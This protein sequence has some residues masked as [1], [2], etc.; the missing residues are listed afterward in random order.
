MLRNQ[1]QV[2]EVLLVKRTDG[3]WSLPNN[4]MTGTSSVPP[5]LT[6]VV[7]RA[8]EQ[9]PVRAQCVFSL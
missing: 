7:I 2:L 6:T 9:I 1:R 8:A 5:E 4:Y 3:K